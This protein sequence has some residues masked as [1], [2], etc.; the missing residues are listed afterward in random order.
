MVQ[1]PAAEIALEQK[2]I[3]YI[4]IRDSTWR[5]RKV[6]DTNHLVTRYANDFIRG[7]KQVIR[8]DVNQYPAGKYQ[9]NG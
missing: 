6:F 2:F 7:G 4:P 1:V 8:S 3:A 9:I 5:T